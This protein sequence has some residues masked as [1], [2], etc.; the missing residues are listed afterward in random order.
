MTEHARVVGRRV[1]VIAV[2][3]LQL[4]FVVRAYW[5]AHQEFGFH[6]FNES[7]TWQADIVRVTA[8][9]QRIP[10]TQQWDGYAWPELVHTRYLTYPEVRQHADAGIENQLA[11][12]DEALDYVASHTPRDGET[13]YLEATVTYWRNTHAPQTRV[14]RSD[15]RDV[16]Q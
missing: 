9:G 13:L 7:T 6:M 15:M 1:V 16:A 8:D 4:F 2:A 5:S 10:V 12:L 14:L 11:F 3:V